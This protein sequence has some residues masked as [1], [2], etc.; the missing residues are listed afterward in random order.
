M[1]QPQLHYDE[2]DDFDTKFAQRKHFWC[3][4]ACI[5]MVLEYEGVSIDQDAIVERSYGRNPYTGEIPNWVGTYPI[6]GANL[7]NM[8]FDYDGDPYIVRAEFRWGPPN[9]IELRQSMHHDI[10]IIVATIKHAMVVIKVGYIYELFGNKNVQTITVFDPWPGK[11]DIEYNA[12]YFANIIRA[13]W[14][15]FVDEL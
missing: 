13:H 4:A 15:V 1:Y 8:N 14:N 12:G 6:I 5:E 2:L 9:L 7:N 3:W 11:G 10:P